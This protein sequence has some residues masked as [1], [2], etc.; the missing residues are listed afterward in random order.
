MAIIIEMREEERLP[1]QKL[2]SFI[3]KHLKVPNKQLT[4]KQFGV[5][6]S[7]LTYLLQIGDWEGVLRRPPLGPTAPKAHDMARESQVLAR[8]HQYFPIAPEVYLFVEKEE[9]PLDVP[10]FIMEKK[11][12]IVLDT[13]MPEHIEYTSVI[14]EEISKRMVEQLVALH[15]I[16]PEQST[17]LDLAKPK[18][19]MERQVKNWVTR[20]ERVDTLQIEG[21][22]QLKHY[23]LTHV[24]KEQQA[25]II[26]YDYKLNN[27]MF[28]EDFS[29]M[30]GLFD[31]EM[32]TVGDPIA[33][34]AVAMSYWMTEEDDSSL[35][36][37]LGEPPVTVLPGFYSREQFIE[38]YA[39]QS[40]RDI[41]QFHYYLTFAYFKLA[42]IGQQ[43]YYRYLKGQTTD[44]RFKQFDQLV[45][46]MIH[47]AIRTMK[48][49]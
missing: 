24:P 13:K 47:I 27:A 19:F 1:L 8:V 41:S 7:N 34:V 18:G 4:A 32:T 40:G 22:E 9:S 38:S 15:N 20:Y 30:T 44:P 46:N 21:T 43:I 3:K 36:Y 6:H 37:A 31:W 23:L 45:T 35:K 39:A 33:D 2:E 12:G 48:E 42:V 26:H 49:G 11:K 16:D 10:F 25:T 5:G 17:L 14:G 29:K 28:S